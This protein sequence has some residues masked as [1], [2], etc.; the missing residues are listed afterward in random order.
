MIDITSFEDTLLAW[1]T[2]LLSISVIFANQKG[3]RPDKP[4]A[5]INITSVTKIGRDE[6]TVVGTDFSYKGNR[7]I[8]VSLQFLGT[9]NNVLVYAEQVESAL[10]RSLLKEALTTAEISVLT[11]SEATNVDELIED[12]YDKRTAISVRFAIGSTVTIAV[13]T[14]DEVNAEK[15]IKDAAGNTVVSDSF[16]IGG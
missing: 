3:P 6:E 16:N 2:D 9:D 8:G 1:L 4:Y 13:D 11:I 12:G 5:T 7:V 15:T 10:D 14:I